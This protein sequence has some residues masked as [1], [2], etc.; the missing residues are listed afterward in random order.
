MKLVIR[1]LGPTDAS[2]YQALRLRA[3]KEHPEAFTS[4]YEE[5]APKPI[6]YAFNRLGQQSSARFW[7]GFVDGKLVGML[8]LDREPRKKNHHKALVVGMYVASEY[9]RQGIARQL[10]DALL[11]DARAS[12]VELLVRTVT[13][14]N[15]SAERLYQEAGFVSFGIEPDAI[16]VENLSYAKNHMFLQ[17]P[18]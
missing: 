16:R 17:I 11:E 5:E 18:R 9:G 15:A 10:L 3:L 13:C 1:R 4:A 2:D 7:G 12:E 6:A 8:G 14:G